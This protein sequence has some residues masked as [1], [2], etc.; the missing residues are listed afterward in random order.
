MLVAMEFSAFRQRWAS[1]L[2]VEYNDAGEAIPPFKIGVDRIWMTSN[3]QTTFGE[4]NTTDLEQFLKVKDSF[5]IDM[6]SVTGTPLHY[7][8]QNQRGFASGESLKQNETRFLAKVRDR[9][10]AFGQTWA[11]LMSFALRLA[12][13]PNVELI[14]NWE[15][16][17]PTNEKEVLSNLLLKKQIGVSTE[18]ALREAGYGEIEVRQM[19]NKN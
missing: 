11:E 17:A 7:F 14:T 1:G 9:Q 5:R 6:A 16:P 2:E 4:F 8:L 3:P 13:S 12:G 15:D 18:Q 19:R 10:T